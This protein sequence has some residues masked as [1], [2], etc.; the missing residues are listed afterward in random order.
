M[1]FIIGLY[2]KWVQFFMSEQALLWVFFSFVGQAGE[3]SGSASTLAILICIIISSEF[4]TSPCYGY[5]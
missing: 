2:A 5:K 3:T 1:L 4:Q